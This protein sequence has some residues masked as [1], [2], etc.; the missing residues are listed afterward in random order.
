MEVIKSIAQSND[1]L[2]MLIWKIK[3]LQMIADDEKM[4]LIERY[5]EIAAESGILMHYT[6]KYS[7][8]S[9][10]LDAMDKFLASP[11][12]SEAESWNDAL[13]Q[14]ENYLKV[15]KQEER[16]VCST[17]HGVK[18]LEFKYVFLLSLSENHIPTSRGL[19]LC[20]SE[21]AIKAYIEDERR[22]LYVAI[23][24]AKDHLYMFTDSETPS[25]FL[26]DIQPAMVGLL[27]KVSEEEREKHVIEEMMKAP[28]DVVSEDETPM[29]VL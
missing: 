26:E 1:K 14:V 25:R 29:D 5:R 3:K 15:D 21:E 9:D 23:T 19:R 20:K 13:I 6:K 2:L 24:R 27:P 10:K 17:I 4:S 28:D 11:L 16:V 22:V 18:G 7:Q 8:D 12:V